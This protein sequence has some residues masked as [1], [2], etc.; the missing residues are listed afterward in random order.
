MPLEYKPN[1]TSA[2][3]GGGFVS[4]YHGTPD[5]FTHLSLIHI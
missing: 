2:S 3:G 1:F 5:S 4:G